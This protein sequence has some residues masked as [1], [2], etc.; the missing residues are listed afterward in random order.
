MYA[1]LIGLFFMFGLFWLDYFNI[2]R[3]S[4]QNALALSILALAHSAFINQI[5]LFRKGDVD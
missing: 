3:L 4:E 5:Y 1:W 2:I